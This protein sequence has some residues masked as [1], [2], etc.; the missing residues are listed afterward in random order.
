MC[1]RPKPMY[2]RQIK[3]L[4][5]AVLLVVATLDARLHAADIQLAPTQDAMARAAE[6]NRNFGGAGALAVAGAA[7]VNASNEPQGEYLS[8]LQFDASDATTLFDAQFGPGNWQLTAA[9][10]SFY[11]M[12]DPLNPIFNIGAGTIDLRWISDD[13][14]LEGSGT[15]MPPPIDAGGN[16]VSWNF[17]QTLLAG[18]DSSLISTAQ[19]AIQ[20][21]PISIPLSLTPLF[22]ND[23]LAGG[24]VSIFASPVTPTVGV[25]FRARDYFPDPTTGPRL[26]LTAQPLVDFDGDL[27][28]DG[29]VNLSD[30]SPFVLALVDPDAYGNA[31]PNCGVERADMNDDGLSDGRDIAG[32]VDRLIP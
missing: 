18:T 25:T 11:Q 20:T 14:W 2:H 1:D 30:V 5:A 21:G 13:N 16:E 4:T 3:R 32:F 15:P 6:P 31:F 10:L 12:G 26:V 29:T 23:I 8:V 9:S 22:A 19:L 24:F 7:A 28:C 27:N 17:L